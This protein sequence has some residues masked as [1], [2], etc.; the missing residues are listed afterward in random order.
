ME[1][2]VPIVL[3]F[4]LSVSN[5]IAQDNKVQMYGNIGISFF[6]AK[7]LDTLGRG[8]TGVNLGI[9]LQITDLIGI[10]IADYGA[11]AFDR[12]DLDIN[13]LDIEDLLFTEPDEYTSFENVSGN[14]RYSYYSLMGTL[15]KRLEH[16]LPIVD[17][18]SIVVKG[19]IVFY[20]AERQTFL[21]LQNKIDISSFIT[22]DGSD[23]VFSIGALYHHT[24]KQD[25]E[26]SV[27]KVFGDAS[28]L[29]F[30]IY[31]K[32]KFIKF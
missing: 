3:F 12:K 18:F 13:E 5:L 29:S 1:R 17:D 24:E 11:P 10:E 14:Y 30:N 6:N 27:R 4:F 20:S 7:D 28:H 32:Y 8:K 2:F 22:D 9:G 31:W 23:M 15:T 16:D 21:H 25:F 26:F 19:G